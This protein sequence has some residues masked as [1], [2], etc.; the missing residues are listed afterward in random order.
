MNTWLK[1][2]LKLRLTR[3]FGPMFKMLLNM[4]IDILPFLGI[5][6]LIL[7]M[8]A[9]VGLLIFGQLEAFTSFYTIV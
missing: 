2:F 1:L 4:S 9:S 5:W 7:L 8:F 6:A 3:T